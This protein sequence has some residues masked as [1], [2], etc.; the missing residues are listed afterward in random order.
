MGSKENWI[1]IFRAGK[2]PQGEFTEADLAETA[3]IYDPAAHAA[4][5]CVGHPA[6]N[7]PAYGWVKA[8]QAQASKLMAQFRDVGE[9][10]SDLVLK[11]AYPKRSAAFYKTPAGGWYLRHVG[12]L[13][14]APPQIKGLADVVAFADQAEI[15][16]IEFEDAPPAGADNIS[17]EGGNEMTDAEKELQ[18]EL[19][20]AREARAAAE[21]KLADAEAEKTQFAERERTFAEENAKLKA[22]VRKAGIAARLD[23]LQSAGKLTPGVRA[24]GLAEFLSGLDASTEIQFAEEVKV[25]QAE[26]VFRMLEALPKQIEFGEQFSAGAP[27]AADTDT[28]AI[29]A[30]A[31]EYQINAAKTGRVVSCTDAVAAVTKK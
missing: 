19:R 3:R 5:A 20:Q 26:F 10:F 7:L 31:V 12:F 25:S 29:A 8:L 24:L 21:M 6:S 18:E 28:N 15:I 2:Y 16:E 1:E 27:A 14:A 23:K 13:G 17:Q 11:G 4:P 9:G 30:R 22:D